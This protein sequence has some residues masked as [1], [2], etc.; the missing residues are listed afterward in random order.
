MPDFLNVI[1]FQLLDVAIFVVVQ[2]NIYDFGV[3]KSTRGDPLSTQ[4]FET[5]VKQHCKQKA[6]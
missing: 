2:L 4:F 1:P 3:T 5:V 6:A